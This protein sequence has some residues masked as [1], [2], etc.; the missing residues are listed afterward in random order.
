MATLKSSVEQKMFFGKKKTP[1]NRCQQKKFPHRRSNKKMRKPHRSLREH[2]HFN[3]K[4]AS[5]TLNKKVMMTTR[6]QQNFVLSL[7]PRKTAKMRK[8]NRK[9]RQRNSNNKLRKPNQLKNTQ[10]QQNIS[11]PPVK[12]KTA[13]AQHKTPTA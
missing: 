13:I 9:I 6:A 10:V 4:G 2:N 1:C 12:Q 3:K 5:P 7:P 8:P 11:P